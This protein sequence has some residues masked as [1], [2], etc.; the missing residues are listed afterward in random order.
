MKQIIIL[1]LFLVFGS[2]FFNY[3]NWNLTIAG[4]LSYFIYAILIVYIYK[5]RNKIKR[6]ETPIDSWII[7]LMIIPLLCIITGIFI[8][9]SS[10][11]EQRTLIILVL[12]FSFYYYFKISQISEPYMESVF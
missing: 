3:V 6:Y 5:Y 4:Q 9:G 7:K 1:F 10:L 2:K 12:T 8:E 11:Y